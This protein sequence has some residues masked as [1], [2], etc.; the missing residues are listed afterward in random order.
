MALYPLHF[1]I[2]RS[3][4]DDPVPIFFFDPAKITGPPVIRMV[5]G[6]PVPVE[7]RV[8]EFGN[9]WWGWWP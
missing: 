4:P 3:E 1:V 6:V 2:E 7:G 5:D 9:D 8:E